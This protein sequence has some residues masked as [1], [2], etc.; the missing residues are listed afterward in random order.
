MTSDKYIKYT[1]RLADEFE[2][3]KEQIDISKSDLSAPH[4]YIQICIA[5]EMLLSPIINDLSTKLDY[6]FTVCQIEYALAEV[7]INRTP[8]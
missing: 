8:H 5:H 2:K 7:I 1:N 6:T 3:V 4:P